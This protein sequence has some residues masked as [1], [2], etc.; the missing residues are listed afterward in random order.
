MKMSR[1]LPLPALTSAPMIAIALMTALSLPPLTAAAAD[2]DLPGRFIVATETRTLSRTIDTIE[3]NG[4]IDLVVRQSTVPT[5]LI[6]AEQ[7]LLERIRTH[8]EGRI[9]TISVTGTPPVSYR[10]M[11]IELGLPALQQLRLGGTGDTEISGF[12]GERFKLEQLGKGDTVI[13]ATYQNLEASLSGTG[14]LT[15]DVGATNSI[16]LAMSGRGDARIEG[17]AKS[18]TASLRGSGDL[19]AGNLATEMVTLAL[20]GRGN[21][22]VNASQAATVLSRGSGDVIVAGKPAQK[23]IS[24]S[25]SGSVSF[26]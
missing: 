12:S 1:I 17:R 14:D 23:V 2:D 7:R 3:M 6:K 16:S 11:R 18:L 25:G 10:P 5:M 22:I 24:R 9:L 19:D 26:R 13:R 8:Q 21:A 15:L 4:P 20:T